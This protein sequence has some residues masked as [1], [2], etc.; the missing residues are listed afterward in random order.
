ML[1]ALVMLSLPFIFAAV[2]V[3]VE[4]VKQQSVVEWSVLARSFSFQLVNIYFTLIGSSIASTIQKI[5]NEPGCI[6]QLLGGSVPAVAG[7]FIQMI[8]INGLVVLPF[9]LRCKVIAIGLPLS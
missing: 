3:G 9:E 6:F 4:G 8:C 5:I 7:F 2:A 1:Q